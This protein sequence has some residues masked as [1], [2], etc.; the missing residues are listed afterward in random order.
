MEAK[1]K[2]ETS[3]TTPKQKGTAKAKA[4]KRERN[5]EYLSS[6]LEKAIKRQK[7]NDSSIVKLRQELEAEE[8]ASKR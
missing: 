7:T 3:K 6:E 8:A 1:S 5:E 2:A 4:P